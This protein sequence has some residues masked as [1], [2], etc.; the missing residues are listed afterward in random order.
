MTVENSGEQGVRKRTLDFAFSWKTQRREVS[1]YEN[2]E[3]KK[4]GIGRDWFFIEFRLA[5]KSTKDTNISDPAPIKIK[6]VLI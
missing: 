1:E 5:A 6:I 2:Q 3:L 4:A